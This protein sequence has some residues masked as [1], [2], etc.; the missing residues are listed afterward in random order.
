MPVHGNTLF[1]D[2]FHKP[3]PWGSPSFTTQPIHLSAE[4]ITLPHG[5]AT[6]DCGSPS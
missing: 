1:I 2:N 3:I 6:L 5:L 4:E